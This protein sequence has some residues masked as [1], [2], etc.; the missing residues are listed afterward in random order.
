MLKQGS[1]THSPLGQNNLQLQN[2]AALMSCWIRAVEYRKCA[3]GLAGSH[4]RFA[5]S[6]R[7]KLRKNCKYALRK[8][9]FN[10]LCIKVQQT[11]NFPFSLLRHYQ[12]PECFHANNCCF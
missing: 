2:E 1:K 3:A 11:L 5:R 4:C 6:N 8:N 10:F 9:T 7:A 12:M